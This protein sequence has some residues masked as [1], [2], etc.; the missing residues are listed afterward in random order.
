MERVMPNQTFDFFPPKK[1]LAEP[2]PRGKHGFGVS[3]SDSEVRLSVKSRV[4]ERSKASNLL[5]QE[6][7]RFFG[8]NLTTDLKQD[9]L[10]NGCF[11]VIPTHA[12]FLNHF[13]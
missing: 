10:K 4:A 7:S 3:E 8:R 1:N 2:K 11:H 13:F 12:D 5:S 9:E 6:L